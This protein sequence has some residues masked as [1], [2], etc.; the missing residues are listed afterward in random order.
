M[1]EINCC[2]GEMRNDCGDCIAASTIALPPAI[3]PRDGDD[4]EERGAVR[5]GA[6]AGEHAASL[7]RL[8]STMVAVSSGSAAKRVWLCACVCG[9][10][11]VCFPSAASHLLHP[12]EWAQWRNGAV[13]R[14]V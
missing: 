6:P 1:N 10:L 7:Q 8:Y 3:A 4:E 5:A 11:C 9:C 13:G 2:F 14:G 12:G